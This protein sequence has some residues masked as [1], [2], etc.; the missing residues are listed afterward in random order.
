MLSG[1]ALFFQLWEQE[2]L[3]RTLGGFPACKGIGEIDADAFVAF[4]CERGA[5]IL[6][7]QA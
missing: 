6:K 7:K 5:Q 2:M 3:F 1:I 4:F